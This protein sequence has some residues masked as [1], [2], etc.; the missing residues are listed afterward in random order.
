MEGQVRFKAFGA[1]VQA[2][3][4]S[5]DENQ[6]LDLFGESLSRDSTIKLELAESCM[7]G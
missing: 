6:S 7:F 3:A 2:K 4:Y 5:F 1:H